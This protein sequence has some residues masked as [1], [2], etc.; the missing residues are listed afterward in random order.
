VCRQIF[1][2]VGVTAVKLLFIPGLTE[3]FF[4]GAIAIPIFGM[5]ATFGFALGFI[6][7]AIGPALVIQLMFEVQE[8]RLGTAKGASAHLHAA[9][10]HLKLSNQAAVARKYSAARLFLPSRLT[11]PA[12]AWSHCADVL[13]MLISQSTFHLNA[14][15]S[16][17]LPDVHASDWAC[18]AARRDADDSGGGCQFRRHDR[19][20]RL[21]NLHQHRRPGARTLHVAVSSPKQSRCYGEVA[22]VTFNAAFER[23]ITPKPTFGACA[24]SPVLCCKCKPVWSVIVPYTYT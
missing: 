18:P 15:T 10:L 2:R 1:K 12:L 21:H 9:E 14:R 24:Q 3:A 23:A 8:K 5:S 22:S 11:T 13:H 20:H 6:L 19:P 17:F 16:F 4:D 7:K